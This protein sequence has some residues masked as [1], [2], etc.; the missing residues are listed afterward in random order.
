MNMTNQNKSPIKLKG[1]GNSLWVT[2]D[3]TQP[4]DFLQ[5]ELNK[6]FKRMKHLVV[7]TRVVLDPGE[8]GAGDDLIKKLSVFLKDTFGV[9]SVSKPPVKRVVKEERIQQRDIGSSWQN[10]GSEVLML[11]GRVRSGQKITAKKHVL[12]LGDVNP[13]AEIVAGGDVVVMGSLCGT[14]SA[15]QPENE[16]AIVLSLDFRP[17]Q[18]QIGGFLAAG[19][20]ASRGKTVEFASVED[21]T[22]VVKDYLKA[23]PFG[24]LP[25]PLVR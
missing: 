17:T 1:V 12:I 24:R 7:N 20:R 8:E 23:N 25:Q 6:L 19:I 16:D 22:I 18:V 5:D 21:S 10:A 11:T 15:G 3:P 4:V 13:G 9:G 14:V 2:F